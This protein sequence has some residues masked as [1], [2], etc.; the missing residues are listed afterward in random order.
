[1]K[2]R[3]TLLLMTAI[4]GLVTLAVGAVLLVAGYANTLNTLEL[5]QRR[6][7]LTLNL[8]ERG[9]ED[10]AEPA[11]ALIAHMR[12][13]AAEGAFRA[14]DEGQLLIALRSSLAAAPQ[15]GGV[16]FWRPDGSG[17]WVIRE[18]DGRITT[19]P[20]DLPAEPGLLAF[21]AEM[22]QHNSIDWG[23]PFVRNGEPV[24]TIS[25]AVYQDSE[26]VGVVAAGLLLAELSE[27]LSN[28][29]VEE[30]M[31][32]FALYGDDRVLAHP[33]LNDAEIRAR[34]TEEQPLLGLGE[35]GDPVIA[36][37]PRLERERLPPNSEF[38]LRAG[39]VEGRRRIV[40]S[41]EIDG[42]GD[43]PWRIGVHA[44][45]A[46]L[47]Q[48]MRRLVNSI[49]VGLGLMAL[50]I[51]GGLFL[52]SRIARPVRAAAGAAARIAELD[53]AAIEKLPPSRIRE[54]DE[55]SQAFNR[56]VT[57]LRWLE[58]YV[59]RK[60]V[61]RLMG[62][63]GGND[64]ATRE[65]VLTVM[66]TDITG[67]TSLSER[68]PPAEVAAFLNR[69]FDMVNHCIE[70]EAGTLDKYIGDAAM[71]FWGAPE[72]DPDHAARACRAALGMLAALKAE[73]GAGTGPEVRMKIAIHTGPLLVGNIGAKARM[74][75][76]VIG[77]TVNVASRIEKVCS[78]EDDGGPAI[79]L[80]SGET[81]RAAG[82][83]FDFEPLG[84]HSVP[85]RHEPVEVWRLRP[86]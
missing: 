74:N 11:R 50:S 56:M 47:N 5:L 8:V 48:Q 49:G 14:D 25:G 55:Q 22:Q 23:D 75:Y 13:L 77:D 68:M 43:I 3:I 84:A 45:A 42:F 73:R 53:F 12:R 31:T 62:A 38:E 34:S 60:L 64:A 76:T 81:K 54:L 40:L 17:F 86:G 1:M 35:I 44:P 33:A 26:F 63:A 65:A 18:A 67:F 30:G 57:G 15:I 41:Q 20:A 70:A 69:H 39:P 36:A 16:V 10:K 29:V 72:P 27:M 66:F 9:I 4:G 21:L 80:V 37:F 71:A 79:I 28:R 24:I 82:E 59:P 51:V 6:A 7:A 2:I 85:G 58:T 46:V 78:A 52:A 83:G 19:T 61:T 32:G